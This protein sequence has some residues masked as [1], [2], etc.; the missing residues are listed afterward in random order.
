M[1]VVLTLD[2]ISP[3]FLIATNGLVTKEF[4]IV[5]IRG[6]TSQSKGDILI[7]NKPLWHL[8]HISY[9]RTHLKY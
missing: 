4:P 1:R 6:H 8:S 3:A 2:S 9:S 7:C 5:L